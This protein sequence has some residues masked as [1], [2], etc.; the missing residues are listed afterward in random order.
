LDS[1]FEWWK[2]KVCVVVTVSWSG[3]GVRW[4]VTACCVSEY[5]FNYYSGSILEQTND[6]MPGYEWKADPVLEIRRGVPFDQ[7]EITSTNARE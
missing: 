7:R 3:V 6:L 2:C 5:W 4:F 1:W